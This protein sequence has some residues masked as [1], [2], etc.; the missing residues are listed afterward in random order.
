MHLLKV[1][2]VT[3]CLHLADTLDSPTTTMVPPYKPDQRQISWWWS[4]PLTADDPGVEGLLQF[5]TNNTDIVTT[6]IARCGIVTCVRNVSTHRPHST[7]LNN[8]GTGGT[9]T[10]HLTDACLH[11]LPELNK[12]GIRVEL[13][14]GEDDAYGSA[15]YLFAHPED[16]ANALIQVAAKYPGLI[17]GFNLDLEPGIGNRTDVVRFSLFLG[18]VTKL[19]NAQQLRFSSDV[20]CLPTNSPENSFAT[21]CHTLSNSGVNR[22]MNM[23]TYNAQSYEEWVYSRLSPALAK[24]VQ[25]QVIGIGLGCWSDGE[26][27][28]TT[29]L[30]AEDRICYLM[31]QSSL[32]SPEL[33]MFTIAMDDKHQ[34]PLHFWLAP[35]RKWMGGGT[36]EAKIPVRT[37]CPNA[38]VGDRQHSWFAGGP[39]HCCVSFGNRGNGLHCNTT[40]AEE[41][42]LSDKGM[43]WVPE[44]YST[45]PYTCCRK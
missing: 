21:D 30:S 45:H 38:T 24:G 12:L 22:L 25:H 27:W 8:N 15:Q 18:T 20:N 40:C 14:L 28:S 16:T 5:A 26:I 4:S 43:V 29:A 35:L 34:W 6:V 7:C 39:P 32:F 19:L 42:C 10:G 2:L 41:E 17:Q 1:I 44:N 37:I 36:C 31:N 11:V 3:L 9:I 33:D 23:R 13:W